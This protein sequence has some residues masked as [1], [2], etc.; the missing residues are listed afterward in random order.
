MLDN[1]HLWMLITG[2]VLLSLLLY[3]HMYR[4]GSVQIMFSWSADSFA[5]VTTLFNSKQ[6]SKR[7]SACMTNSRSL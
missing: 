5:A 1:Q 4:C 7:I 6:K 3:S 2:S